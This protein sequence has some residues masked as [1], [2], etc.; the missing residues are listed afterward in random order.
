MSLNLRVIKLVKELR[1]TRPNARILILEA[2][3]ADAEEL[4]L[5]MRA[6]SLP[7]GHSKNDLILV[8]DVKAYNVHKRNLGYVDIVIEHNRYNILTVASLG[9]NKDINKYL[10][11]QGYPIIWH[12]IDPDTPLLMLDRTLKPKTWICGVGYEMPKNTSPMQ[13]IAQEVY[14]V[15][16]SAENAEGMWFCRQCGRFRGLIYRSE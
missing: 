12:C 2:T 5:D 15:P 10:R 4:V 13:L 8:I 3:N 6:C 11:S 9:K 16:C 1:N 7:A 14:T